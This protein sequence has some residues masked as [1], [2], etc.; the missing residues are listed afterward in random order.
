MEVIAV[1]GHWLPVVF[2]YLL[3]FSIW[4]Y[5]VLDG[6][7]LGVGLLLPFAKDSE[8]KSSM[9]ASIGPF[10]DANETWMVLAVGLLLIAFPLAQ[11]IVLGALYLPIFILLIGVVMRGV[12][13]EMR[14]HC[15][16]EM[17]NFWSK[18]FFL[19]SMIMAISQGFIIGVFC[20]GL[21]YNFVSVQAGFILGLI[22]STNY[23]Y[24]GAAWLMLKGN[25]DV[26]KLVVPLAKVFNRMVIAV[27][28]A[29]AALMYFYFQDFYAGYV[30]LLCFSFVTY[31]C[32]EVCL[33]KFSSKQVKEWW[34]FLGAVGNLS[35][36]VMAVV[37]HS[38]P[39]IVP[40]VLTV[41]Q[42]S[43]SIES[44]MLIF[45][46]ASVILPAILGYTLLLH[47]VFWGKLTSLSHD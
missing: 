45:I 8:Q 34:P 30:A 42:A 35:V 12:S 4:L 18:V 27:N 43:A 31:L 1:E 17:R 26:V 47:F 16:E 11:G 44:L 24:I 9:I 46:G 21:S 25:S 23:A 19:G 6:Y 40:G 2:G 22:V 38:A 20:F 5:M 29:L 7:D 13:F 14:H 33:L 41:W 39:Y 36:I 15:K 3:A 10:W 32:N 28:V 37:Y